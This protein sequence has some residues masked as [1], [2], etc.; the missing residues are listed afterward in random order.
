LA[1]LREALSGSDQASLAEQQAHKLK[2][3]NPNLH[4][5]TAELRDQG[6]LRK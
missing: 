3:N 2:N 6:F 5:L 4:R 1:D